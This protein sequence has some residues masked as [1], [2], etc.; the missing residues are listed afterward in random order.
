MIKLGIVMD[1]ISEI[2]IKKDSSFAMLMAAQDRG[3]QLFYMEMAD[4][5]MVNGVAMANMRP[6]TVI[7]DA[8]KWYE[9]GEAVDTPMSELDVILM[10]KDPPFDTEFI[11]ATYMLERAEEQGVLIVNKPQSLRDANEKLFT[12]WF[13]EFT[14]ETIVTRDAKRIRAFHQAKGDIILK[15]LDG[16]GGTSIFRVKQDDPNLGVIIETLTSYGQQ[17]AMA[18]A[19]I[20]EITQGDKRILVVDGEPV[21][22]AL[23]RIPMKGETRGNLAAGGSGVAQPLSD[24]DWA[25]ARAIGPELKKRGLI[26]VGLDV[27]GDKLTEINVT[28]PTCI[29]EIQAAFDVD[30]TGML[31]DAI[32]ARL[33]A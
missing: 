17:Y 1:P 11:Y 24:S 14:P 10:R 18:Q 25:I 6:L 33:K 15:P 29:R 19:F 23:A 31:M 27:I 28:S 26:F 13:S 30:I 4:L 20:P 7:N 21:P 3:Y 22:Y 16:M 32:E 9:L 5:A 8:S 12:A 2:N